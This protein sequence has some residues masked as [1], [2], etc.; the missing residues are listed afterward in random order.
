M[1]C[2]KCGHRQKNPTAQAGGKAGGRAK[3]RK[4]FAVAGQP[5][6][7]ARAR[8]WV[9]RRRRHEASMRAHDAAQGRQDVSGHGGGTQP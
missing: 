1:I 3:V 2:E 7:D 4:G 6:A 8:A 9:T 5:S